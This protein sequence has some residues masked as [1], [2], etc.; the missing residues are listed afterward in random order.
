MCSSHAPF[1]FQFLIPHIIIASART[2]GFLGVFITKRVS[3]VALTWE[4]ALLGSCVRSYMGGWPPSKDGASPICSPL[5]PCPR[6]WG[7]SCI[8]SNNEV[9]ASPNSVYLSLG[10]LLPYPNS[11]HG[12]LI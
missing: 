5:F 3:W 6:C 9:E 4:E 12:Y 2:V 1:F 11:M 8:M 10:I 7:G